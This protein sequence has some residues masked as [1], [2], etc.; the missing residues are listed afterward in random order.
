MND[1]ILLI[2]AGGHASVLLETLIEQNWNIVGYVSRLK[3][4]NQQ[5][6]SNIDWFQSDDDI[7][8]F[9][10]STVKLVNGIGSLPKN[11]LRAD[12]YARY[13]AMDYHF[14]TVV[15]QGAKVSKYAHLDEG[16]QV[17]CGAIIQTGVT[18]GCNSIINTGSIIEHG[19]CIGCDNH[20]APGVTI[21]GQVTSKNNVHFG[22]GSSVIQSININENVV[23]GAGATIT[24]DVES[25]MVC[26]PA[27]IFKKVSN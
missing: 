19:T 22:T 9:D 20:I 26:Y 3:A 17:M 13:K 21:S 6:F 23:I 14:L 2:G 18:V 24:K 12:F 15:S 8:T 7:L 27:Q 10:K 11:K 5:L 16:V 25:N 4:V 1:N